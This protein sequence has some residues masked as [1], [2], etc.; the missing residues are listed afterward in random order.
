MPLYSCIMLA[1]I[2]YKQKDYNI[3][4]I[5]HKLVSLGSTKN[6]LYRNEDQNYDKL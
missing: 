2:I 4:V 5:M 1:E 3:V 6:L